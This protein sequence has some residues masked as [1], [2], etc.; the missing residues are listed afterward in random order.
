MSLSQNARFSGTATPDEEFEHPAG[1]SIARL[2]H[3]ALQES[4]W[5]V[6]DFDNWRDCGWSLDCTH[7]NTRLQVAFSQMEEG[8]WML[9]VAPASNPGFLGKLFGGTVSAQPSETTELAKLIH[10][11]LNASGTFSDFMW[12]WDGFPEAD[13]SD[14]EPQPPNHEG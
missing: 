14:A 6:T 3:G 8:Q 10:A 1:A 2:L 5:S 7:D 13:N 12:P 4:K 11:I 9:Q